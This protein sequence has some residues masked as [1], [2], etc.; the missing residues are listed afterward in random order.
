M[1]IDDGRTDVI[2]LSGLF[3]HQLHVVAAVRLFK[4]PD[5]LLSFAPCTEFVIAFSP[6]QFL[7]TVGITVIFISA[8]NRPPRLLSSPLVRRAR[9]PSLV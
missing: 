9:N 7:R 6:L 5:T 2:C 4:S 8:S 1:V 3:C